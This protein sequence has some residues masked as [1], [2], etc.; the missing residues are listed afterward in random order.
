M[1][2]P[3]KPIPEKAWTAQTVWQLQHVDREALAAGSNADLQAMAEAVRVEFFN[4]I[5]QMVQQIPI[6]GGLIGDVIE[7][8][9]GVEDGDLN[10]LGS[11]VNGLGNF[12]N[13][14]IAGAL[15]M[16]ADLLE[17][18]PFVGDDLASVVD[19]IANGLTQTHGTATS[20]QTTAVAAQTTATTAVS[21][22]QAAANDA[23][24]AVETADIAYENASYWEAECVVSSAGVVLGINELF[25]GLCQNVPTGR[26]RT[27]TDL[28]IALLS[29]PAGIV[30]ET[31]K[32]NA[33]GTSSSVIHTATLGANV[34]R[35]SYN[36]LGLAV[37]DKERIFWNVTSI[38]GTVEPNVLQCLIFGV[39]N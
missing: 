24:A 19:G 31:K 38:T 23:A 7:I 21:T 6:I 36:N 12:V 30:I 10:D 2:S 39:I 34:T 3:D 37:A 8:L 27:I 16:L 11:W 28:H 25:I 13:N 26:A 4:G 29:Q 15:R 14:F 35:I 17:W 32:W 9:T 22:A 20:A 18:I 1:T 5:Y 33:A